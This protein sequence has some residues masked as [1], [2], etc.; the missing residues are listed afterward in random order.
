MKRILITIT[1][2]DYEAKD[3]T[4]F[5]AV[6]SALDHFAI[7]AHLVEFDRDQLDS[8][9]DALANALTICVGIVDWAIDNGGDKAGSE[10]IK[11][12]AAA[13]ISRYEDND[14]ALKQ[15]EIFQGYFGLEGTTLNVEFAAPVGATVAEKDAAFM[16]ALAQQADVDYYSVG[17]TERP[18]TVEEGKAT[19]SDKARLFMQELLDSAE[20]LTGIADEYGSRTLSDLMYLQNAILSSGFID[21]YPDESKV[22]EIASAL[23]SG[24]QWSKFIKLE[25]LAS[26]ISQPKT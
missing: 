18:T 23:P 25:Y 2:P 26:P 22:L 10:A 14:D 12:M 4:P 6:A 21:H 19:A 9:C 20:T 13:A 3:G 7:P 5:D 24:E 16:A 17:V 1:N 11:E 8:K 15:F